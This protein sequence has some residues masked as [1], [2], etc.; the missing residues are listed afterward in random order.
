MVY[1]GQGFGWDDLAQKVALKYGESHN[2]Y[3]S[4]ITHISTSCAVKGAR[5]QISTV[6]VTSVELSSNIITCREKRQQSIYHIIVLSHVQ[7]WQ[8]RLQ[9]RERNYS[10]SLL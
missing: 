9:W 7:E 1:S 8:S 4:L 6:G 2:R 5:L 3:Y 10:S